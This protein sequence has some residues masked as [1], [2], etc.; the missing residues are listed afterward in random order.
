VLFCNRPIDREDPA[1]IDLA[2]TALWL[3]GVEPPAHMDGKV[4]FDEVR[5]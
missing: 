5:R 3:F 2:P 4:L 1:L